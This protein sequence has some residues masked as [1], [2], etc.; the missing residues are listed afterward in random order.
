MPF[1][2]DT[3]I[4]IHL[5]DGDVRVTREVGALRDAVMISVITRV[6]LEGGVYREPA[7]AAVRRSR[8][9]VM[10]AAL[11]CLAFDEAAAQR[12]GA[13]VAH[14]G[15]SRRNLLDRMIAAQALL[16]GATLITLNEADFADIPELRVISW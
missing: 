9:D 7:H 2:L 3:N 10:L 12:Y 11:P 8:L 15:Y 16:H 13:I 6:E 5:R 4:A 14:S 1:I